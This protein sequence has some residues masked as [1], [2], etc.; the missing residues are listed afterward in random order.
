MSEV[1]KPHSALGAMLE[2]DLTRVVVFFNN[3]D[4]KHRY[5]E[6]EPSELR[7]IFEQLE[8]LQSVLRE[9]DIGAMS[10]YDAAL[11]RGV[12]NPANSDEDRRRWAERHES[13][14]AS[15][16]GVVMPSMQ[17]EGISG[18]VTPGASGA[19]D[20]S[21]AKECHICHR[22]LDEP[23]EEYCSA[24]HPLPNPASEPGDDGMMLRHMDG[25]PYM[26]VR[27]YHALRG[28]P[29]RLRYGD[30]NQERQPK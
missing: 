25:T 12:L 2:R 26:D 4:G 23:G 24:A 18:S 21:P 7:G 20:S 10:D 16:S 6:F 19:E 9:L 30:S 8:A 15:A 28:D 22:P 27:D 3:G 13:T 5:V 1:S 11:V 17:R 14:S 29:P